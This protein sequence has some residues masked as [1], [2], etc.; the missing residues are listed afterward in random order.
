K[1]SGKTGW[2]SFSYLKKVSTSSAASKA[3]KTGKYKTM[4]NLNMRQKASISSKVLRNVKKGT[5]V[6]V[7]K[8]SGSWGK[9]KYSGKTGWVSFSYLKKVSTSSAASKAVKTGKYK[10][11]INLN[12][13][14]KASISSKVLRNVKKGTKVSVTK[15]SGSWGKIKYSGKTGWVALKYLKKA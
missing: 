6:S 5:K 3:V 14:Q 13:R 10:T 1:Y 8:V 12:I 9:I 15:I 4:I 11:M 7:T 2:V